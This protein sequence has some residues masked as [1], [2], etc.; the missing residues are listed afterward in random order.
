MTYSILTSSKQLQSALEV[1][2][3]IGLL[4]ALLAPRFGAH[5][6]RSVEITGRKLIRH[7]WRAVLVAAAVPMIIRFAMLPI[8][9][10]PLP[11]VH[12]EFSYLLMA[13]TFAHGRITNPPPPQ[14]QH[15]EAEYILLHPTYASQYQPGQGLVMAAGQ[16]ITGHPWWG[17]WASTGLM[18]GTICWALSYLFP[19]RW[20]LCGALGAALQF[21]IFGFWMNSY[22][23]GAVAATGGALVAGALLR[24]RSRP[25]SSAVVC[26]IGLI[27]LFGSRPL[28]GAIWTGVAAVWIAVYY[29]QALFR[30]VLPAVVVCAIG[31]IGLAYYNYRVT[32]H[33]L[34]P[35][36]AE[37]RALYGTPQSFWWQPAVIVTS[38]DSPQ[39]RDNYLNQLAF[40]NRRY[41]LKSLWD[42]TWRRLRDFWR[43]FIGPFFTPALFFIWFLRRDRRIRPWLFASIPFIVEHATYHAWYPQQSAA[44][45]LLIVIIL[46]QCWRHLRLWNR[47]RGWGPAMSRNLVAGFCLAILLVSAGHAADRLIPPRF[48]HMKAIWGSLVPN[49]R[50]RDRAVAT[51][52]R[53]PGKHLVFVHYNPQ[54]P[55]IDEWVFNKAEI[56]GAQ[57]VFS[58]VIDPEADS[59]LISAMK[60]YDVWIADVDAGV[61]SELEEASP[62]SS[63]S[64]L[65]M[66]IEERKRGWTVNIGEP[67]AQPP[68]LS[69]VHSADNAG[70]SQGNGIFPDDGTNAPMI[71]TALQH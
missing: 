68:V 30:L 29:R 57:I 32:D 17:V 49:P 26:G 23:G 31:L 15:F 64:Y 1:I 66:T 42:S 53:I 7:R 56:P 18:C 19:L 69:Q 58:R 27:V 34:Q 61:L 35:P 20:A 39:L 70:T 52:E 60:G 8:F 5:W 4:T 47:D 13:D 24:M 3:L 25:R 55:Y 12:D 10:T 21:G 44:E 36:Y 59:A 37:G 38:F 14:W 33:P 62:G 54:H 40:W 67:G 6:F 65:A 2:A 71:R 22:F 28:E 46:V 45:T 51:L 16:I 48:A 43:F 50:T 41:S 63:G 9:S 11:Y